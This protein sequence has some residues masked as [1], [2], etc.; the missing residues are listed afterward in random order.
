MKL[1]RNVL[2]GTLTLGVIT[3]CS[4][5]AEPYSIPVSN[6]QPKTFTF[7]KFETDGYV[8]V[9]KE[10]ALRAVKEYIE[11]NSAYQNCKSSMYGSNCSKTG[12]S[13]IVDSW[14]A[15]VFRNDKMFN[16]VYFKNSKYS[17]G[18]LEKASVSQSF[19]YTITEADDSI[20]I[21][22]T[23]ATQANVKPGTDAI[24]IPFKVGISDENVTAWTQRLFT[25][26]DLAKIDETVRVKGEFNIEMTPDSVKSNLIREF[27]LKF[28]DKDN[29][30]QSIAST[31]RRMG[32]HTVGMHITLSLYR[33][34]TKLEYSISQPFSLTSDAQLENYSDKII[35]IAIKE[36]EKAANA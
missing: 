35:E 2:L 25:S 20:S 21:T 36:L 11:D 26:S 15:N 18:R 9:S 32:R 14:G 6:L 5:T 33:G 8:T 22:V 29:G 24:G 7:K 28:R 23:P 16:L 27:D 17:S 10:D 13:G 19:P 3:G 4:M 34:K 12:S 1:I 31:T 30:V